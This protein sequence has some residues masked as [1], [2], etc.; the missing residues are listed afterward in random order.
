MDK[1]Y[2][3]FSDPVA[4]RDATIAT[5]A[6][7]VAL[8]CIGLYVLVVYKIPPTFAFFVIVTLVLITVFMISYWYYKTLR[9]DVPK[10][11]EE[12]DMT[13]ME[14]TAA[15]YT[16]PRI[17]VDIIPPLGNYSVDRTITKDNT[18]YTGR[19]M[20]SRLIA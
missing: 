19:T 10:G 20:N 1:F 4:A 16:E 7:L 17:G 14:G 11:P 9:R 18:S 15:G 6:V 8:A 12:G 2:N 13:G 3:L 5:L